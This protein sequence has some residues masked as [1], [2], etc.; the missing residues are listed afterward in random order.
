MDNDVSRKGAKPQRD[1]TP[2]GRGNGSASISRILLTRLRFIG[3]IVLTT[4]AIEN[5]RRAYPDAHIA[6]LGDKF[7]ISLLEQNPHLNELIGYDLVRS[8]MLEQLRVG[9]LLR[10]KKYDLV[11]DFFGNP[12]SALVCRM[13]GARARVGPE[14]KGRGWLYTLQ[15]PDDGTP[16][17]AV[18]YHNATIAAAGIPAVSR[19]TH[20]YLTGSERDEAMRYLRS[21]QIGV[22]QA[23][24]LV[25][26][27]VGASWPAK[28]WPPEKFAAVADCVKNEMGAAVLLLS[29]PNDVEA[30]NATLGAAATRPVVIPPLPL[31]RLAA[32]ISLCRVFVGNDAGPMH[33]AAALGIP[34]IGI[35]GPGEEEIWFPYS[36][37]AGH[38]AL[39]KDVPCHPCHLDFC[40]KTGTEYMQCMAL[41]SAN[42]VFQVLKGIA[43]R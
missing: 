6:Y 18:D 35:F 17:S 37:T 30:V 16:K 28:K 4:P 24:P 34:T 7:A 8:S 31:R 36:Q 41:L 19:T 38:R 5:V 25:A 15:V 33:I 23:R 32:V 10:R 39:R 1:N 43:A 29:G 22:D 3:D 21:E 11:I 12:R 20:L 2:V 13:S 9:R 27:H 40:N 42:E 14:R 26:L